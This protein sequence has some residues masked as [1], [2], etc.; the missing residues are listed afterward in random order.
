M[1]KLFLKGLLLTLTGLVTFLSCE[2]EIEPIESLQSETEKNFQVYSYSP[3]LADQLNE[4]V[5]AS[6]GKALR[7]LTNK[8]GDNNLEID[9][10]SVFTVK[11][12]IGNLTHA[13][14]VYV[15]GQRPYTV[16]N[17]VVAERIDGSR[18]Q[19]FVIEY[20]W[21][22]EYFE[23][24]LD[25]ELEGDYQR[26]VS[27]FPLS[28]FTIDENGKPTFTSKSNGPCNSSTQNVD[29]S[30]GSGGGGYN[31]KNPF[32][33]SS[34]GYSSPQPALHGIYYGSGSSG[35]S[36][37]GG[38]VEV[39]Q[40][41][42][43][44]NTKL[45]KSDI[46]FAKNDDCPNVPAVLP[47]NEEDGIFHTACRSF[48][49]EDFGLTGTK[50]AAV[51]GIEHPV[52]RTGRCPGVGYVPPQSTYYFTLPS[53]KPRAKRESAMALERAFDKLEEYFK[54]DIPCLPN[55]QSYVGLLSSK[56]LEFTQKEFTKIGGAASKY[57]PVGWNGEEHDY[58]TNLGLL[59][60]DC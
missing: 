50:V 7:S 43:C 57:P 39:G 34:S 25:G 16:L 56:L 8:S 20:E 60:P 36:S 14:R 52:L 23:D 30:S 1:K 35:G 41:C 15:E 37:G 46:S 27:Y 38:Y 13:Y 49:Y 18:T 21:E 6:S 54:N 55:G 59:V 5:F 4:R 12:S 17:L 53:S 2:N 29:P 10:Q 58:E 48:E 45:N 24:K 40:G 31:P 22:P 26:T 28:S 19:S 9:Q 3:E 32:S 33:F 44:D 42:F 47:V 11:D 51:K